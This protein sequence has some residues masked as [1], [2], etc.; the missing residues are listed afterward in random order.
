MFD[1]IKMYGAA[2]LAVVIAIFVGMFKYRGAKID[3]LEEDLVEEANK[4]R[5]VEQAIKAER[6]VLDFESDN[7]VAAAKAEARDYEDVSKHF[8]SI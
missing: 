5:V 6:K 4:A 8:Y 3:S 7:R 1:T 2:A